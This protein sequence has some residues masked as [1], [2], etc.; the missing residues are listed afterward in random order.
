MS[1]DV[2]MSLNSYGR[3]ISSGFNCSTVVRG[4]HV[5]Q[6]QY[7]IAQTCFLWC[8]PSVLDVSRTVLKSW[9]SL[10]LNSPSTRFGDLDFC[11]VLCWLTKISLYIKTLGFQILALINKLKECNRLHKPSCIIYHVSQ[12]CSLLA[13]I[14][15]SSRKHETLCTVAN[16]LLCL[17]NGYWGVALLYRLLAKLCVI[18]LEEN[19][20]LCVDLWFVLTQMF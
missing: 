5:H 8:F 12:S 6:T 13:F 1:E 3:H 17:R 9:N 18:F 19:S 2:G 7:D 11:L 10:C 14:H 16:C 4:G 20:N 15:Y